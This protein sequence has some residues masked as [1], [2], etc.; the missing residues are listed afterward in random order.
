M[1]D[2]TRI[3]IAAI[4]TALFLAG[5]SAIG[6]AARSD[7]PAA[8]PASARAPAAPATAVPP[9]QTSTPVARPAGNHENE[10]D[11]HEGREEHALGE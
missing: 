4:V 3:K 8:A 9:Q 6:L 5:I 11:E 10:D 2:K 1:T 7:T